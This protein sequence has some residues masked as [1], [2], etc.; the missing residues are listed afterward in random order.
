[1][2]QHVYHIKILYLFNIVDINHMAHVVNS[3]HKNKNMSCWFLFNKIYAMLLNK[4]YKN[5]FLAKRSYLSPKDKSVILI[6][7]GVIL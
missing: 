2:H 6:V 7:P 1:M 4:I 5:F 3:L